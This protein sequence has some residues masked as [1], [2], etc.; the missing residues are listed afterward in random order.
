[1]P[2]VLCDGRAV[3]VRP[4]QQLLDATLEAGLP[5]PNSCRAIPTW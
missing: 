1:M 4:G 2:Q 5:V 3:Q